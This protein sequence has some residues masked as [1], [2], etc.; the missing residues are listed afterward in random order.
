M[1]IRINLVYGRVV[2]NGM[3]VYA[4]FF[5]GWI[6]IDPPLLAGIIIGLQR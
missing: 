4:T 3:Q 5:S 1:P 2:Q 6:P